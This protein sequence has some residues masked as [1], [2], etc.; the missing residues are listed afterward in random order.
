MQINF[1]LLSFPKHIHPF[2]H[3]AATQKRRGSLE[4]QDSSTQTEEDTVS[5]HNPLSYSW[6]S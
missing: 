5:L 4:D 1:T 2:I 3:S 6:K